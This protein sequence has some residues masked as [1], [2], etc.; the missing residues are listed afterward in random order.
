MKNSLKVKP[1]LICIGAILALSAVGILLGSGKIDWSD[2]THDVLLRFRLC[3]VAAAL[4]VGAALSLA[5]MVYQAIFRN[6]LAD[7]YVLGVSNGAAVGAII[8]FLCGAAT[9]PFLLPMGAFLG[10]IQALLLVLALAGGNSAEGTERLL[11]AGIVVGAVLSSIS[12]FLVSQADVMELA[13]VT[14]WT[15]GDLQAVAPQTL[16]PLACALLAFA[17]ATRFYANDLNA[18]ALGDE[19]ALALGVRVAAVRLLL[20]TGASLLAAWCVAAVGII[21]FVGL[22]VPQVVRRLWGS[23]Q[24]HCVLPTILCGACFLLLCDLLSKL[25]SPIRPIPI[26]VLTACVGGVFLLYALRRRRMPE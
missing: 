1:L 23:D 25:S 17:I 5:G 2:W 12:V 24:R 19:T 20:L 22:I 6:P 15:L 21:S 26:G 16:L 4:L 8:V 10:G 3:R 7:A 13:S 14:W 18:L 9:L 11:L